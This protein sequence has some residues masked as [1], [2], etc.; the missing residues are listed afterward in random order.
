MLHLSGIKRAVVAVA[1]AVPAGLFAPAVLS[2]GATAA[3]ADSC[4]DVLPAGTTNTNGILNTGVGSPVIGV[5]GSNQCVNGDGSQVAISICDPGTSPA[6]QG[7]GV[8]TGPVDIW[9]AGLG[10]T[11][12]YGVVEVAG[13]GIAAE[14]T[15]C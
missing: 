12:P 10:T 5:N 11:S 9:G 2:I 8:D 3:H 15:G 1:I 13:Y 7:I 14:Q 4:V 6:N